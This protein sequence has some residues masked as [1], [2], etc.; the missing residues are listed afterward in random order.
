MSP[1]ALV[2]VGLAMAAPDDQ[3][4]LWL[5]VEGKPELSRA[6][7][8]SL[9]EEVRQEVLPAGDSELLTRLEARVELLD[10]LGLEGAYRLSA[11]LGTG[12]LSHRTDLDLRLEH[13]AGKV[14]LKA[15]ERW[16]VDL[17]PDTAHTL[18]TRLGAELRTDSLRPWVAVEPWVWLTGGV[19]LRRVRFTLGTKLPTEVPA[20]KVFTHLDLDLDGDKR[21]V[22][23]L[24]GKFGA[25]LNR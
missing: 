16:Q 9:S 10:W 17:A 2:L 15:R 19:E 3:G 22:L 11:D 8:V 4:A 12:L 14:E 7:E 6:V 20:L 1:L 5:G 23:G 21:L 24:R 13:R 25:E 18:R